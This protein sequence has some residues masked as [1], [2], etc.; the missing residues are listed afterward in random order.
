MKALKS[1]SSEEEIIE[2]LLLKDSQALKALYDIYAGRLYGV[3]S[4][5]FE[6]HDTR[7][8]VLQK[9]MKKIWSDSDQYE[10]EKLRFFTWMLKIVRQSILDEIRHSDAAPQLINDSRNLG[11]I[12]S[13]FD[14]PVFFKV[15]FLG[16]PVNEIAKELCLSQQEVRKSLRNAIE[17]LKIHYKESV[18]Q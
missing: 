13:T 9:V 6:S 5:V 7:I 3:I 12:V 17:S 1:Y 10:V 14:F 18:D 8:S 15:F 2:G 16:S 11:Q 4:A